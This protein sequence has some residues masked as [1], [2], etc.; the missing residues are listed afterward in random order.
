MDASG[1]PK[2]ERVRQIIER[3]LADGRFPTGRPLPPSRRLAERFEVSRTTID[4]ALQQLVA[5]GQLVSR[6]RRGFFPVAVPVTEPGA[7]PPSPDRVAWAD[8]LVARPDP[9]IDRVVQVPDYRRYPYPFLP[10]QPEHGSFPVRAWLRAAARAFDGD[11]GGRATRDAGDG[12][13]S[14]LCRAV[15]DE[16]LLP[17]GIAARPDEVLITNGAQQA[18][19][20]ISRVLIGTGTRVGMENPGYVDAARIFRNAGAELSLLP[21]GRQGVRLPDRPDFSLLY[22]TPSHQ[23]PTNVTMP[24]RRRQAIVDAASAHDL[25]VI[26][27]DFDSEIR[28]RG[29]PQPPLRALDG[30]GRVIH[31][32]TFSKV[33]APALRLGYVVADAELIA[34]LR[35]ARYL[36]SK[37]PSGVEQRT[38]ALFIASGDFAR[39][40]SRQRAALRAK[41]EVAAEVL[42]SR[43]PWPDQAHPTGGAGLWL[44]GPPGYDTTALLERARL[45]GVLFQP[46]AG[47]FLDDPA[48]ANQLRLGLSA[49]PLDRVRPGLQRLI[50]VI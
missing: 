21:V 19:A 7:A 9:W 2:H 42:G 45:R 39:Q 41:W 11:Q 49:I 26:E 12:D 17:R 40:V 46:G 32:G 36:S 16:V 23:H 47:F 3:E 13:D 10:G 1:A 27:D 25:I 6:P 43:F 4:T 34:Q 22:L 15:L 33:L 50:E 48:P 35:H 30:A 37:H 24:T 44:T 29:E 38:L 14:R 8:H 20:L 28:F 5:R 31:V 18:L